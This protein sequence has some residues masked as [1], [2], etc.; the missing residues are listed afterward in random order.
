M[1]EVND[2]ENVHDTLVALGYDSVAASYGTPNQDPPFCPVIFAK[3]CE[4][5]NAL[6][7]VFKNQRHDKRELGFVRMDLSVDG[8]DL[9]VYSTHLEVDQ[10]NSLQHM[11]ALR[12]KELEE[13]FADMKQLSHTNVIIAGDFNSIRKRDYQYYVNGMRAWDVL[14][15]RFESQFKKPFYKQTVLSLFEQHKFTSS[16]DLLGWQGPKVTNWFGAVL[17][18]VF[19]SPDWPLPL[20]GAYVYYTDASDHLPVVVDVKR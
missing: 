20:K 7:R 2:F 15:K 3:N 16:F 18:F 4:V 19:F 1:Q 13:I 17:D 6:G 10:M 11:E 14:K 9:T 8:K 5:K 12:T